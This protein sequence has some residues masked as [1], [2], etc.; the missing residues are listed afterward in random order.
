[1][2]PYTK[3]NFK[4]DIEDSAVRFGH[5]PEMEARFGRGPL[6]L[7]Q[8]G[9]SYLRFAPGF[10]APFGHSHAVQE[11]VYVVFEGSG[12]LKLGDDVID[13]GPLDVVRIAPGVMRNVEAGPDGCTIV[14]F[15][16]PD[17][18]NQDADMEPGWWQD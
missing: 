9:A 6:E 4:D 2:A 11:E 10:R 14:A 5:S 15:G 8:C 1:M 3:L 13:I 7:E 12:R 17:T 18:A 16:A